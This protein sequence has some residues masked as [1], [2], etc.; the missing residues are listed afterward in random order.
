MYRYCIVILL[1]LITIMIGRVIKFTNSIDNISDYIN[2]TVYHREN[3]EIYITKYK[4]KLNSCKKGDFIFFQKN[5]IISH[6][7]T[8]KK[9]G[10]I[11]HNDVNYPIKISIN[12][13]IEMEIPIN[14]S[15]YDING[16]GYNILDISK[17]KELIENEEINKYTEQFLSDE[18]WYEYFVDRLDNTINRSNVWDLIPDNRIHYLK[19]IADYTL[20]DNNEAMLHYFGEIF[21]DMYLCE[22][23]FMVYGDCCECNN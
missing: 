14:S 17:I 9:D 3:N 6:Y 2:N 20:L 8:L 7:T 18:K 4:I 13:A 15:D 21:R 5:N 10:P 12:E 11:F 1:L 23:G 22:H 16:Q 19:H